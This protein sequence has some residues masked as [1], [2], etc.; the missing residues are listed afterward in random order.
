MPANAPSYLSGVD[1]SHY[2]GEVDWPSVAASGVTFAFIKATDGIDDIDPRFAQ[3]WA[4]A[5]A[6]GIVRGA[7]HF[8]R[9]R[10]D[11][12]QQAG[13]FLRVVA[14][15]NLA[16]PPALDVEVTDGLAPLALQTGIR[17][18]LEAVQ[19]A[20]GCTPIVYTDP[21]FWR[22]NVAADF[23]A[24]PL[25]L[26]CYAAEPEVPATWQAWTFWQHTD[27][28]NVNGISGQVDLNYCALSY[29]DLRKLGAR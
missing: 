12:Q 5:K 24:Y 8:F 16:L 14:M 19:A 15:D 18:W 17:T 22:R 25:W 11:A 3:N 7:Y 1:V 26:A 9:P 21:S 13:H 29:E 27:R 20:F 2:Q 28:G 10:L 6:A 4:G 23:S